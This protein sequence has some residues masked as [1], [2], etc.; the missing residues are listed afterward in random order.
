MS[1]VLMLPKKDSFGNIF[2]FLFQKEKTAEWRFSRQ[3]Y[4][5]LINRPYGKG[6]RRVRC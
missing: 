5:L 6:Q 3:R 1:V 4:L 2:L